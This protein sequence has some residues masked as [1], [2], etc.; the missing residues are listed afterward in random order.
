MKIIMNESKIDTKRFGFKVGKTDGEFFRNFSLEE[1]KKNNYKFI[2]ARVNFNDFELINKMEDLGFRI[3][4]VQV[5]F[6]HNLTSLQDDQ[7]FYTDPNIVIRNFKPSDTQILVKIARDAFR[8]YGHYFKNKDLDRKKCL[9]VYEDWAFNS[10]TNKDFADKIIVACYDETPVGYLSFKICNKGI[11]KKYAAGGMGA[12]NPNQRGRG[13]FLKILRAG[14]NWSF[15]S[16]LE[17]CEHNV[18]VSNF[19]VNRS[20]FKAGFKPESPMATMHWMSK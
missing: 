2:I 6:K 20:M 7:V 17:W 15:L 12:V 8:G 4:E 14:L 1:F 18:I 19:P 10:C 11:G 5:T 9:E 3:K 16:K 13:V